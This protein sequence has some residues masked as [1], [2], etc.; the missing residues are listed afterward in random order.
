MRFLEKRLFPAIGAMPVRVTEPAHLLDAVRPVE[1]EGHIETAH[2]LM[3]LCGQVMRYARITGRVKYDIASGLTEAMMKPKVTHFAA[4]TKP[5][6]IGRLL[7][8]IDAYRGHFAVH[9]FLK[10]LPYVFTRPSELRLAQWAEFD[11]E[12]ALWTIPAE[13]MKMRR[14]HVVPLSGQVVTLFKELYALAGNTP[15]LFSSIQAKSSVISDAGP[16]VALL[17]LGYEKKYMTLHGFR[18]MASTN[19]NEIGHRADVIETQLA[20]K[21]PDSVRLAYNRAQ[22]MG[23]R[24][25]MM[26]AWADW[27]DELNGAVSKP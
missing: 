5:K 24:K 6:D 15:Y 13:R 26:Q 11:F 23:E 1:A 27:L 17:R 8:A 4:V 12:N 16:L 10:I 21:E 2:K 22:Y 25:K 20:H 14:P 7:Q 3:Q 18:A 19:L 9:Y